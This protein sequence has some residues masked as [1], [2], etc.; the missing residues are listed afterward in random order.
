VRLVAVHH[1]LLDES[2]E[3]RLV[4]AQQADAGHDRFVG[5]VEGPN[6]DA[7]L[8]GTRLTRFMAALAVLVE[9]PQ[10]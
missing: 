8:E 9:T 7:F 3:A 5:L 6:A 2:A 10:G 4:D 1:L